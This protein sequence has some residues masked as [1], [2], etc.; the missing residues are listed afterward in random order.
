[1]PTPDANITTIREA[2][3]TLLATADTSDPVRFAMLALPLLAGASEKFVAVQRELADL[4][5]ENERKEREHEISL[6]K[7]MVAA[8]R[9]LRE[10]TDALRAAEGV[11]YAL[12]KNAQSARRTEVLRI[13]RAALAAVEYTEEDS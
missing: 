5:A 6:N 7:V 10:A 2:I 9:R 11:L 12:P 1:M 3:D 13:V 8:E 4:R